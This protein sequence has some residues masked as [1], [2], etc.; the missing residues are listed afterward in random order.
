MTSVSKLLAA[1][2]LFTPYMHVAAQSVG[3][4]IEVNDMQMYYEVSGAGDPLVVLHGAYMNIP[5]MGAI[6]PKLAE[7]HEV[8]AV[9]FQGHGRTTDIDRPILGK[10]RDDVR[11]RI[12]GLRQRDDEF[13]ASARPGAACFDLPL[14]KLHERLHEG[15]AKSQARADLGLARVELDE[16]LED[17]LQVLMR[18]TD[19]VVGNGNDYVS[20]VSL[21]RER[22]A[23]IGGRELGGVE[24]QVGND[25]GEPHRVALD[26]GAVMRETHE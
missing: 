22:D 7:T 2:L 5:S 14:V 23:T 6:I 4:R 24:Q 8:Y 3:A 12:S 16:H 19:T 17:V 18:N 15:Q 21:N 9:E 1:A 11:A 26:T 25:L 20:G 13:A 10:R